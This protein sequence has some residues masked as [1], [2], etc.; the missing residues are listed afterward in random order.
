[1]KPLIPFA[2]LAV[3]LGL[4]TSV[5]QQQIGQ[6][7]NTNYTL[8]DISLF[9]TK[10]SERYG[11]FSGEP[12]TL[13]WNNGRL[14]LS[15]PV[16]IALNG[17]VVPRTLAVNGSNTLK[18][19]IQNLNAFEGSFIGDQVQVRAKRNLQSVYYF[20]GAKWFTITRSVKNGE[21]AQFKP[22]PRL[23][24]LGAGLLS[25]D[26]ALA[27]SKYLTP[28]GELLLA[29]L[30]ENEVTET[31]LN[32]DPAPST[33]RRSV[34]AIQFGV[35]RI[36]KPIAGTG[37]TPANPLPVQPKPPTP[38][39]TSLNL[40]IISTLES[41][42]N[43][44]YSQGDT[45]TRFDENETDFQKTWQMVTGNQIPAPAAPK[46][47]FSKSRIV[48]VFLGQRPTG[49]YSIRYKSAT[50]EANTLNLV[51][52]TFAPNPD[53]IV[54]QVITSPFVILEVKNTQFNTVQVELEN[55]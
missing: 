53:R 25:S 45:L 26:E 9:N 48:T 34:L 8:S 3:A 46:I 4:S 28:K 10:T 55:K 38:T 54:T 22:T 16:T 39:S 32:L 40:P 23:S 29:T 21:T 31:R 17:F 15:K 44:N 1:M 51:V 52:E 33:Y 20:D 27:L 19:E 43:S 5:G 2:A 6:L 7:V 14:E 12:Q 49:G 50:I 24:P 18:L 11:V 41:G 42:S 36:A 35:P 37:I 13:N 30:V 47:D